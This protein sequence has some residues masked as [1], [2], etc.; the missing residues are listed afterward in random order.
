MC[1]LVV[2]LHSMM[3]TLV[4]KNEKMAMGC[5]RKAISSAV[6]CPAAL[7]VDQTLCS[8]QTLYASGNID[9]HT[10]QRSLK[11]LVSSLRHL[12]CK[13]QSNVLKLEGEKV[14]TNQPISI[15]HPITNSLTFPNQNKYLFI[16]F[17]NLSELTNI[18][19]RFF[20]SLQF[21]VPS[22]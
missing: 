15:S 17:P 6:V 21:S 2:Q 3:A 20:K 1:L 22:I 7:Q 16:D 18:R 9:E 11:E 19:I 4:R 12:C 14:P 13:A 8:H 5:L 10:I